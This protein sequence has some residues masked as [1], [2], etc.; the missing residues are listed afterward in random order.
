MSV[1]QPRIRF[2]QLL[3]EHFPG[4]TPSKDQDHFTKNLA[5]A[6]NFIR[7]IDGRQ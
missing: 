2:A 7:K 5:H 4:T 3:T 6:N 1:K